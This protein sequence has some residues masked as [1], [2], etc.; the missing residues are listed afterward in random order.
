MKSLIEEAQKLSG[1]ICFPFLAQFSNWVISPTLPT[2]P[3]KQSHNI[4][5][6]TIYMVDSSA[7]IL[8]GI[9]MVDSSAGILTG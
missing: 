5:H 8:T 2:N 6:V 1:L 9:Y 3:K 4:E 7:G